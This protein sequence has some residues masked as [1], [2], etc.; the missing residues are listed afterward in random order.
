MLDEEKYVDTRDENSYIQKLD[1][2]EKIVASIYFCMFA[3]GVVVVVVFFIKFIV[4]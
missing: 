4:S 3:I 1:V 2:I